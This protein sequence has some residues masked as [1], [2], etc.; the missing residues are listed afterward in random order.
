[1]VIFHVVI[2]K[3][4]PNL[5]SNYYPK[6][7]IWVI[8][9]FILNVGE[10]INEVTF[11]KHYHIVR[12]EKEMFSYFGIMFLIDTMTSNKNYMAIILIIFT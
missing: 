10:L 5:F 7:I 12:E 4:Y 2:I 3:K 9:C 8:Y 1:M 6:Y 11:P